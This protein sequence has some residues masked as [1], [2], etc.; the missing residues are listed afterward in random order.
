MGW[1]KFLDPGGIGRQ[2]L[3]PGGVMNWAMPYVGDVGSLAGGI[4]GGVY[5]GP[6]GSAAGAAAGRFGGEQLGRYITKDQSYEADP[7]SMN[8]MKPAATK[9]ARDAAIAYVGSSLLGVQGKGFEADTPNM[10]YSM[11]GGDYGGNP[12][13]Y[14]G[15]TSGNNSWMSQ[16]K[17][18]D[19]SLYYGEGSMTGGQAPVDYSV[20][21]SQGQPSL[22]YG[23]EG[24][25]NN[26]LSQPGTG[27][28]MRG[29]T[30]YSGGGDVGSGAGTVIDTA[31][32]TPSNQNQTDTNQPAKKAGPMA[33]LDYKTLGGTML[34]G[35]A[36]DYAGNKMNQNAALSGQQQY[37]D[38][39]T[40]TPDRT[41]AYMGGL[42]NLVQ[43]VYADEETKK[44]K[45]V[46]EML[47]GSGRGGGA[48]GGAADKIGRERR[49]TA[50]RLLAQ[51]LMTTSQPPNL[52][53]GAF[54]YTSPEGTALSNTGG[55]VGKYGNTAQQLAMMQMLYGNQA[56]R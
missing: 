48:Y 21:P 55:L 18:G 22:L 12:D 13:I 27:E 56:G 40:W 35:S 9:A 20:P 19:Q 1:M 45:S 53:L 24:Y 36:L 33:N 5:G 10:A 42:N 25:I 47:A 31:Q 14:S 52:P 49:E 30:L 2:V 41:S 39:T 54:N 44:R 43:G 6:A 15:T 29:D 8:V 7:F 37:R 4:I 34:L 46:A 17:K 26:S 50:S 16:Y 51:G 32:R 28:V 3:N 23:N 11:G 38:A